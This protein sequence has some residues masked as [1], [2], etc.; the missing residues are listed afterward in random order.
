MLN[1][2]LAPGGQVDSQRD[3]NYNQRIEDDLST[4]FLTL[5]VQRYADLC[6]ERQT[7]QE[8]I[9]DQVERKE[10]LATE[11][12]RCAII[13]LETIREKA[14]E[15]VAVLKE[16]SGGDTRVRLPVEELDETHMAT[17]ID[18]VPKIAHSPLPLNAPSLSPAVGP[19]NTPPTPD[20]NYS[21]HTRVTTVVGPAL[22]GLPSTPRGATIDR[23]TDL[24]SELRRTPAAP[25]PQ[26][27]P[28]SNITATQQAI[29][30]RYD[31]L[32]QAAKAA[33][34]AVT[35]SVI[36]WPL[37]V[38][39]TH[40]YP[41]QNVME[42]DLLNSSVVGFIQLYSQWKWNLHGGGKA[43]RDDWEKLLSVI[44]EHRREGRACVAKVVWILRALVPDKSI[45]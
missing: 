2:R 38:S 14:V 23:L 26:S 11:N 29:F 30:K 45:N 36:P 3:A 37:L 44:P 7:L 10:R 17:P 18:L 41:M 20:N 25:P 28:Q 15:V 31:Q 43:M 9:D 34:A 40:Q 12:L 8:E 33:G 39:H 24:I 1:K 4:E 13:H 32:I 27:K 21:K 16:A 22:C 35:M 5:L 19:T 6:H 42:K